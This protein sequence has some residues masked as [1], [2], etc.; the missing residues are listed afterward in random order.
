MNKFTFVNA[1]LGELGKV[2]KLLRI[3]VVL[4]TALT[5]LY[6]CTYEVGKCNYRTAWL[7]KFSLLPVTL[8][9]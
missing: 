6:V 8:F 2:G 1:R 4:S 5:V 9:Q 7:F 3:P